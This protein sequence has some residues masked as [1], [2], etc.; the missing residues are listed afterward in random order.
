MNQNFKI[1]IKDSLDYF[2]KLMGILG[3]A[4]PINKLRP[5]ERLLLAHLLYY[6][7]KYKSLD[8]EE[9]SRLIFSKETRIDICEAMNIDAQTFY[10][11]KS[12]LKA[13][14]ILNDEYLNK[15]FYNFYF[16]GESNLNFNLKKSDGI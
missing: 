14:G 4:A 6:N 5:K 13:K 3:I 11:N 1:K 16:T 12:Q 8:Q 15:P 10:N 7:D 2:I 9:R